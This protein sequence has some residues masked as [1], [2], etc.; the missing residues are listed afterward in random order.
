MNIEALD[1]IPDQAHKTP[2]VS[3]RLLSAGVDGVSTSDET[4]AYFPFE[5]ILLVPVCDGHT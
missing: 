3:V 5:S 1:T 4:G 2:K